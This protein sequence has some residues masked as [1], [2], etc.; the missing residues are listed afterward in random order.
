VRAFYD[1]LDGGGDNDPEYGWSDL[2]TRVLLVVVAL[3][4]LLIQ[5]A[6]LLIQFFV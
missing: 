2:L 1:D 5:L 6:V 3:A 4:V